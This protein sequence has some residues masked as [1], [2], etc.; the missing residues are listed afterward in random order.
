[1]LA[2][3][4]Q[5]SFIASFNNLQNILTL[6][7]ARQGENIVPDIYCAYFKFLKANHLLC[8][9]YLEETISQLAPDVD[10]K[11]LSRIKLCTRNF[12]DAI[13]PNNSLLANPKLIE[14][15][16]NTNGANLIQG[17]HNFLADL[18]NNQGFFNITMTDMQAFTLGKNLA[19]TPGKIIYQNSLMQLIQYSPKT[20]QVYAEP[21]LFI[22]PWINKYYIL[23]ICPAKSLVN[24]MV[25][26]GFTVFIISWVNPDISLSQTT[27]T[28]Y[29]LQGPIQ[30]LDVIHK[31]YPDNCVHMAG[32]CIGGTLLACTL[33]YMESIGDKRACT[34]NYLATLLDFSSP[35]EL[36][37]F[38]DPL[39]LQVIAN[40][41]Q[42]QGY[43]NG[44][45]L[46][47][48]FNLLKPNDLIWPHFINN[49][50]L[51]NVPKAFELL[52]W[53][54][55]PTNLPEKMINFYLQNMYLDNLLTKPGGIV[56]NNVPIDLSKISVPAFFMSAEKDHITPWESIY[57]GIK[58]HNTK[59]TFVLSGSGHVASIT[60]HPMHNKYWFRFNEKPAGDPKLWL[61]GSQKHSGS[62]WCF[63]KQ[64]LTQGKK[65]TVPAR[66][67]LQHGVNIIEDAPGSYV[68]KRI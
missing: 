9:Q 63:W 37:A 14:E 36:G 53:N 31:F 35:G 51:G 46:A 54:A 40:L 43:L 23:D 66:D 44:K 26:Q 11:L 64:C 6:L 18:I 1:M 29:M 32:Y 61:E 65:A 58:L 24:W 59:T 62:W 67:P 41:T 45:L 34:A 12:M 8:G 7:H 17:M 48:I 10:D 21:I 47:M 33:A 4:E 57:S 5:E 39:Q 20:T 27:F 50:L 38:I 30:A 22:P 3:Q 19:T 13:S 52:Y 55:D 42:H 60:N 25:E 16:F 49:Y 68:L 2:Q 28:D 15:T 56:L